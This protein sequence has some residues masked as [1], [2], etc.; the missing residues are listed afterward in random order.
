[1][2]YEQSEDSSDPDIWKRQQNPFPRTQVPTADYY[3]EMTV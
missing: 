1:M 2:L 3:T